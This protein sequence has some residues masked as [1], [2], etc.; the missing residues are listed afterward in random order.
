MSGGQDLP[1]Y[2]FGQSSFANHSNVP[3][4][5]VVNISH[6]ITEERDMHAYA[7]MGCSFQAGSATITKLAGARK[8]DSVVIMGVGAV[9]LSAIMAAK[10]CRCS[11][12]IAVDLHETRL[13]MAREL[14]ATHVI[15]TSI[16]SVD[17]AAEIQ[18]ITNGN[19]PTITVDTTGSPALCKDGLD[20]TADNGKMILLGTPP[21]DAEFNI[22]NLVGFIKSGKSLVGSMEGDAIPGK[23]IP[24]MIRWFKSGIFPIDRLVKTYKVENFEA[25][26][27]D[28]KA[29]STIKPV[30]LWK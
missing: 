22:G 6:L 27:S 17:L 14:G 12:I 25:A 30:L 7:A 10:I 3:E 29:G 24:Q 9:G 18:T 19:G 23:H 8:E 11:P 5:S 13:Q 28:M 21:L 20:F 15:N 4:S 16:D 2:F 26:I 1:G